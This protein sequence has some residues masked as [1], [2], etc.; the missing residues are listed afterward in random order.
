[1]EVLLRPYEQRDLAGMAEVMAQKAP[2]QIES[3]ERDVNLLG[4]SLAEEGRILRVV[5]EVGSGEFVG[6]CDV[7]GGKAEV[8]EV[9]IELL[10][11]WWGRGA[12]TAAMRAF[13]AELERDYGRTRFLAKI[14]P[15][16]VASLRLFRRL[17]ARPLRVERSPFLPS[18]EAARAFAEQYGE[19]DGWVVALADLFG[20]EPASVITGALVFEVTSCQPT[21]GVAFDLPDAPATAWGRTSLAEAEIRAVRDSLVSRL[22]AIRATDTEEGRMAALEA[23]VDDLS[24]SAD[25]CTR[26]EV[27]ERTNGKP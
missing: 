24:A 13:L 1:M 2:W 17:G 14:M 8:W 25:G 12:G 10:E 3:D 16:N 5:C 19:P 7:H 23:L 15:D 4:R 27:V 11:R 6:Y 18:N 22:L 20:V 26:V 9:G 21:A